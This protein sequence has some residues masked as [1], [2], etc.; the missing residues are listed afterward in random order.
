M[1]ICKF[2]IKEFVLALLNYIPWSTPSSN[3]N[4]IW[5][6]QY[7]HMG[8]KINLMNL[9]I[10]QLR[11]LPFTSMDVK[12]CKIQKTTNFTHFALKIF[13]INLSKTVYI[14]T[15][16]IVTVHICTVTI[17]VYPIILLISHFT[18][19]F[20]SLLHAQRTQSQASPLP[21]FFFLRYTQ[22]HLHTNTSIQRYTNTPTWTNQQRDRSVLVLVACGSVDW[23]WWC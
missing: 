8:F 21:I 11:A 19:F 1:S 20:L 6:I 3:I 23:C 9:V 5:P 12:L 16:A 17:V 15:C 4:S 14:Y 10:G 7:Y 2:S 13:H 22:T 18:P